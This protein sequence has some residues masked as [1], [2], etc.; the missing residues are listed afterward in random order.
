M[1]VY[2]PD[3]NVSIVGGKEDKTGRVKPSSARVRFA[4]GRFKD[5]APLQHGNPK[6]PMLN[7]CNTLSIDN[8][9]M[10]AGT[11]PIAAFLFRIVALGLF[12]QHPDLMGA[13]ATNDCFTLYAC[14][15]T[16]KEIFL[17][18]KGHTKSDTC[19]V[20]SRTGTRRE[21]RPR[22]VARGGDRDGDARAAAR[23]RKFVMKP[24]EEFRRCLRA[25][26]EKDDG[27]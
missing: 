10:P 16:H 9:G 3:V 27:P 1:P 8:E 22:A 11:Y 17:N 6:T 21:V 18:H 23:R 20:A 4:L 2:G 12:V 15:I 19:H 13:R 14:L 24:L 7:K 25:A 26:S 5:S